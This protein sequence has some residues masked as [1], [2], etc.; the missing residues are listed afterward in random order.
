MKHLLNQLSRRA[1][2]AHV[3]ILSAAWLMA[4]LS[5]SCTVQAEEP[6]GAGENKKVLFYTRSAGF[7]HSVVK[8]NGSGLSHA[9]RVLVDLGKKHGFDVTCTKDGSVFDKDYE[10]YDAFIFYTTEDLTKPGGDNEPPMSEQGKKNFLEAIAKGKG[11]VGSHC[12]SDTFHSPG[13]RVKS[14]AELDPYIAMIGGE[15]IRHG[16]QQNATMR[17]TS[18]N[19]PGLDKAGDKFDLHEEWYSLK[20]FAPDMHVILVQE[21]KGMEDADYDRP[22]YPATWAR[23][24]GQGRVFYTSMGHRE[25]VWT[26]PIFESVLVGGIR[27]ALREVDAEIPGNIQTETPEASILPKL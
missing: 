22:P 14:S 12:A 5:A 2:L 9:E 3:S 8:R 13:D 16:R 27:W 24:H 21:T 25:D 11:F 7:E 6:K 1:W 20:N 17:V 26:N 23:K 10:K 15:F 18:K 19:F 4:T